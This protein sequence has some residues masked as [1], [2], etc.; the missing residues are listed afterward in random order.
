MRYR[1]GILPL[2]LVLCGC[3]KMSLMK[4]TMNAALDNPLF[5]QAFADKTIYMVAPASAVPQEDLQKLRA[6]DLKIHS[7][8][9]IIANNMVYHANTDQKRF[10][11]LEEALFN[12]DKHTVVW[13]VRGGYGSAR[14][15]EDLSLLPKPKQEKYFIGSSDITA[16]HLFLSQ[17]WGWKTIHGSGLR[18]LLNTEQD[19]DNFLRMA[20]IIAG[21]KQTVISDLYPMNA[22]AKDLKKIKRLLTGGNLTLVQTSIGTSWQIQSQEKILFLE[23]TLEPGYKIDRAFTQLQ[24]AG[25]FKDVKAIVLGDFEED[26]SK[27]DVQ[28]ALERF[29]KETTIPVF[30]CNAFGHGT[31][32]YPLVYNSEAS[33][34]PADNPSSDAQSFELLM[35][36]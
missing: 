3:S 18:G 4:D 32:N 22:Q 31:K 13:A 23:E 21:A 34:Y 19:P 5:K 33:I 17:A 24:Q 14:L 28:F 29:A 25:I 7:P 8:E 12:I 30:K 16:L 2:L 27:T 9:D 11:F 36:L 1:W 35:K 10:D 20:A 15:I 26:D 6:L